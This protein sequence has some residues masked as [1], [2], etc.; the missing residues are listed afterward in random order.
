MIKNVYLSI[1]QYLF[2][3]H[4]HTQLKRSEPAIYQSIIKHYSAF[5]THKPPKVADIHI[6]ILNRSDIPIIKYK[7]NQYVHYKSEKNNIIITYN[8]ISM[9]HFKLIIY[10]SLLHLLH[11]E[12]FFLHAASNLF[13]GKIYIFIGP[14]GAGKS[15][16]SQ[17]LK[18]IATLFSDD[19]IIIRIY[20][21]K[22][23]AFQLPSFERY[24][25]EQDPL[26]YPIGKIFLLKKSKKC[27]M[28]KMIKKEHLEELLIQA[29][30]IYPSLF[31]NQ[32]RTLKKFLQLHD[33]YFL[34]FTKDKEETI[35]FFRRYYG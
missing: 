6:K 20:K 25:M 8:D 18:S 32:I 7:E 14:S 9:Y 26:G 21:G 11:K 16:I 27:F 22:F 5:I 19:Q 35:P 17:M 10:E 30:K 31:Q 34:Y 2:S 29:I 28:E 3:I 24:K 33:Y 13:R 15:T 23:L 12:G 1:A 4:V